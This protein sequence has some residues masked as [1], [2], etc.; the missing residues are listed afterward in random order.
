M[1][2]GVNLPNQY[3]SKSTNIGLAKKIGNFC[4]GQIIGM[5]IYWVDKLGA[6]TDQSI[7]PAVCR[8]EIRW[9]GNCKESHGCNRKQIESPP[10]SCAVDH[11]V[12]AGKIQHA[13]P[14]GRT[15]VRTSRSR[16]GGVRAHHR[17]R[18]VE[19]TQSPAGR[20]PVPGRQRSA[21]HPV[22]QAGAR[23]SADLCVA[24][25]E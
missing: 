8:R 4:H 5:L 12:H 19:V 17:R 11:R 16:L 23:H 9:M 7:R 10:P 25:A 13:R 22:G 14:R 18:T 20:T 3:I 15:Y 6:N 24:G 21:V 2:D 1:I